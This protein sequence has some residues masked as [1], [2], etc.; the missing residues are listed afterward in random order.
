MIQYLLATSASDASPI[1]ADVSNVDI[2][3]Q[4]LG[5]TD[6]TDIIADANRQLEATRVMHKAAPTPVTEQRP[7]KDDITVDFAGNEYSTA[8]IAQH[9]RDAASPTA[10]SET[11]LYRYDSNVDQAVATTDNTDM[12]AD[13]IDVDADDAAN[14][15]TDEIIALFELM[16]TFGDVLK[17]REAVAIQ[18]ENWNREI[19]ARM[20]VLGVTGDDYDD[21]RYEQIDQTVPPAS[22]ATPYSKACTADTAVSSSSSSGANDAKCRLKSKAKSVGPRHPSFPPPK[23]MVDDVSRPPSSPPPPHGQ[24]RSRD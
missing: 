2:V 24:K 9:E 19:V 17:L 6:N 8:A 18:L 3:D 13:V 4:A 21:W 5:T 20:L 14:G 22:H 23:R 10:D 16:K 7:A 15:R 12:K 1:I 11:P